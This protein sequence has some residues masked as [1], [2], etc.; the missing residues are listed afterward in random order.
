MCSL[1]VSTADT[2]EPYL[3]TSDTTERDKS[4]CNIVGSGPPP[5]GQP[6]PGSVYWLYPLTSAL[7]LLQVKQAREVKWATWLPGRTRI[8]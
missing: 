7:S 8:C 4:L 5:L 1:A 6:G 3:S 2:T